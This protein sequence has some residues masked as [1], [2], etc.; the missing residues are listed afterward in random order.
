MSGW[1]V[2][3]YPDSSLMRRLTT[4]YSCYQNRNDLLAPLRARLPD[5]ATNI[6][7]I[8]GIN[9]S[10]YS[11]WRPFGQRQ[12]VYLW[13]GTPQTP[14]LLPPDVGWIVVKRAVWPEVSPVPLEEWAAQHEIEIVFSVQITAFASRT[15]ETWCLL[16]IR[17][18]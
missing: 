5:N 3:H 11:L 16:H 14:V 6:G 13:N 10:D 2:H 9:D 1:L 15:E 4:V 17:K 8:A 12:V 18:P 7:F